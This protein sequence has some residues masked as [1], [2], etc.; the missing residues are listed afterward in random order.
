MCRIL[1]L[2]I[3]SN[4]FFGLKKSKPQ[5][6]MEQVWFAL[7]FNKEIRNL[8]AIVNCGTNLPPFRLIYE[9]DL[10]QT[11][12]GF[13]VFMMSF[14]F[15]VAHCTALFFSRPC[16]LAYGFSR[17][18]MKGF[19]VLGMKNDNWFYLSCRLAFEWVGIFFP[20]T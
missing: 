6:I 8:S 3:Y 4:S 2:H 5:G 18:I 10:R 20:W 11:I 17:K 12:I 14:S 13:D 15:S 19:F 1:F 7:L 16:L 9:L